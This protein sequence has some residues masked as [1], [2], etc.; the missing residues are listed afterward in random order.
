MTYT[1]HLKPELQTL[2]VYQNEDSYE[3]RSV[4]LLSATLH[5]ISDE[6]IYLC[7]LVGNLNR[8]LLR[9][10]MVELL[11]KGYT[12]LKCERY[13]EMIEYDLP[14]LLRQKQ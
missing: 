9:T 6:E 7:N 5:Y 1:I 8:T 13:G 3:D 12:K 2:R 4:P 14:T 10:L 11:N